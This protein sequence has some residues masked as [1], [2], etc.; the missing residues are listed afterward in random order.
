M[1]LVLTTGFG[2][3]EPLVLAAEPLFIVVSIMD[4]PAFSDAYGFAADAA[5]DASSAS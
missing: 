1:P 4:C 2:F 5:Y 3:S